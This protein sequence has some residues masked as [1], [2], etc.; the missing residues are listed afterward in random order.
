M[1]GF[2]SEMAQDRAVVAVERKFSV[3]WDTNTRN[4]SMAHKSIVMHN[5]LLLL[6][7][8]QSEVSLRL[9]I[10]CVAL[11]HSN[12][13]YGHWTSRCYEFIHYS[14]NSPRNGA[15]NT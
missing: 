4:L 3:V 7:L 14:A 5:R 12:I 13:I 10:A 1:N 9:S 2:I 8:E 6:I 11:L 15:V